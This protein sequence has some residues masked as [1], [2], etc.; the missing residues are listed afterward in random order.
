M[1]ESRRWPIACARWAR[2]S[3]IAFALKDG[4]QARAHLRGSGV[5]DTPSIGFAEQAIGMTPKRNSGELGEATSAR[6][7]L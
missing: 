3:N 4:W 2:W 6:L 7:D 5:G 1:A